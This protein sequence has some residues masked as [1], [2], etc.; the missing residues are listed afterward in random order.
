MRLV[1]MATMCA[2]C[3]IRTENY[4]TNYFV[5]SKDL[6]TFNFYFNILKASEFCS[7]FYTEKFLRLQSEK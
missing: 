5:I 4:K 2:M 6:L 3:N 7:R 1:P